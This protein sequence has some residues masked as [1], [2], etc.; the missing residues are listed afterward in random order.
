MGSYT[1]SVQRLCFDDKIFR[2]NLREGYPYDTTVIEYLNND[3]IISSPS[4]KGAMMI[5]SSRKSTCCRLV[6]VVLDLLYKFKIGYLIVSCNY[7]QY[8]Y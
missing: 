6:V 5:L 8:A 1:S 4:P 3:I 2:Q 7:M